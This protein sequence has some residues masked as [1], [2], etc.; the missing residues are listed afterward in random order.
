MF[1]LKTHSHTT[2]FKRFCCGVYA[3][4]G[5]P[6]RPNLGCKLLLKSFIRGA[7]TVS[8]LILIFFK[9][10]QKKKVLTLVKFQKLKSLQ[11][12]NT[13]YDNNKSNEN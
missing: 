13:F 4:P 8:E 5:A 7:A 1:S 2:D 3:A 11:D 9:V 10:F 12:N 6:K